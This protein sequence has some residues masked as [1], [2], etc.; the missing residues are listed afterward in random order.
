MANKYKIFKICKELNLGH[1]TIISF[2]EQKGIK[3]SGPNSGVEEDIYFEIVE[4][5]ATDKEKAEK[6]RERKKES[7]PEAEKT[8]DAVAEDTAEQSEYMKAI[9]K[10]IEDRAEA[11]TKPEPVEEVPEESVSEEPEAEE[12]TQEIETPVK[13]QIEEKPEIVEKEKKEEPAPAAKDIDKVEAKP[14]EEKPAEEKPKQKVF[15]KID[16]DAVGY[17]KK[18]KPKAEDENLTEKEKKRLKALEMIRKDGKKSKMVKP[19]LRNASLD[20]DGQPRRKKPKKSKRKE[21][22]LREVQDTVK[23]TLASID[24]KSRKIKRHK[25]LKDD[26]D[27]MVEDNVIEVTEFISANDLANLMD[28]PVSEII[29]KC[30][31]LG[32]VVSINQRLDIDT[33]SLLAEE[34][35]FR[36]ELSNVTEF[37]EDEEEAELEDKEEDLE[38]RAPIVTIMGHVDHGKTSLL[39]YLRKSHIVEGEAGG[40]TQHVGAYEVNYEGKKITFLDTPG[41]E[42]FTAMRARGAQVTDI[43]ILIIAADDAVMPQTDEALDHAKAAGVKIVI[44][45]NKVDKPGANSERIRQQLAERNVL[46]EDWGGEYQCAEISAKTGKGIPELL[47]KVLLEAEMLDLRSNP[48]RMAIGHVIESRLDKG[49][50]AIATVLVESGTLKV[51]DNFV[52]GQFSGKVRALLNERDERLEEVK[53]GQPA[54]VVGFMGVPQAGD[55]FTVKKDEKIVRDISTKRQQLKREQDAKKHKHKTLAQISEQ[56]LRG[57]AQ[58]LNILVKADVDGSAEALADALIKLNTNEVQ[59]NVVRKAVG[60]ISESDVLLAAASEAV[61]IGFH[62]RSNAKAKELAVKEEVD[63]RLY[64]VVYDAIN[65]IK[66]A[67]EGMLK[68]HEEEV[69]I[70]QIEV[71]EIFKISRLGVIAGCYV[72]NGKINRNNRVRLIRD[73]VEVYTGNLASLKRFKDDVKEVNSGFE[74]GIQ[75]ENYND[76]KVGDIIEPFEVTH[77]KRTLENA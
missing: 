22:D 3:V 12:E 11:L 20:A 43:V 14:A 38:A 17:K 77:T 39:D 16:L 31:D 2:L 62:V 36:V 40:I 45:I 59:V 61:I 25:K 51:G 69:V 30:L 8:E 37:V 33:I 29:T 60:P 34:Y 57:E 73:D 63:I 9:K 72:L 42:A 44:A 7:V 4:R 75:I 21:V 5:F 15:E 58:E 52:A 6:I 56:I 53:P 55:K 46:V 1:E 18:K 35:G 32:L 26:E 74:C 76:L 27:E 66:L 71:R 28:V 70:G 23:K 48:S 10:S 50:G 24:T 67:L 65:D 47:E 49:K 41:H 54:L 13:E 64:K 19:D 68:P